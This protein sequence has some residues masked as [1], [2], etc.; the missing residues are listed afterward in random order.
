M[1]QEAFKGNAAMRAPLQALLDEQSFDAPSSECEYPPSSNDVNEAAGSGSSETWLD[2]T[3][4][5]IDPNMLYL[6]LDANLEPLPWDYESFNAL[7]NDLFD[8]T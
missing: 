2:G 7:N 8:N 4:M 5:G 1:S 6:Q 3:G